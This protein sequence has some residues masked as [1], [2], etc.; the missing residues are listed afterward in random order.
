[1]STADPPNFGLFTCSLM[2]LKAVQKELQIFYQ[3]FLHG[4]VVTDYFN[5][6]NFWRLRGLSKPR[7]LPISGL[8]KS[9]KTTISARLSIYV[10]CFILSH[11]HQLLERAGSGF[12]CLDRVLFSK[13][14]HFLPSVDH[15][16]YWV[17]LNSKIQFIPIRWSLMM[18]SPA[19]VLFCSFFFLPLY[20]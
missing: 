3:K 8:Y 14:A 5:C 17:S 4:H 9:L 7:L 20:W 6:Y 2:H 16:M 12:L 13:A 10:A 15:S 19:C 18:P 1:M 11:H